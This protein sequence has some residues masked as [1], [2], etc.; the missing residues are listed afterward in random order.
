MQRLFRRRSYGSYVCM[1]TYIRSLGKR[2]LNPQADLEKLHAAMRTWQDFQFGYSNIYI[3]KIPA[4]RERC[5]WPF[6]TRNILPAAVALNGLVTFQ[7]VLQITFKFGS[8]AACF[9]KRA[10][11]PLLLERESFTLKRSA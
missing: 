4:D 3:Y 8:A 11:R 7:S 2:T 1:V 9:E 5:P 10:A 6:E